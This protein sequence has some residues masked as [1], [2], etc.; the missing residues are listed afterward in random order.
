MNYK[1]ETINIKYNNIFLLS[2]LHFGVRANSV[3]W[4]ENH[5]KYFKEFYIPYLKQ[6]IQNGDV[7]FFFRG[8]F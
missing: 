3:E 8:L 2:D 5:I 7:L 1:V 4:L 6:N